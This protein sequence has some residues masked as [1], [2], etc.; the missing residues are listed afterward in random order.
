MHAGPSTGSRSRPGRVPRHGQ[1]KCGRVRAGCGNCYDVD[2]A[3][4]EPIESDRVVEPN[5]E[6][7]QLPGPSLWPVGFAIGIACLLVG[8]IVSWIVAAVGAGLALVFAF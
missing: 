6:H 3:P 5:R 1:R 2:R 4:A 8:L 7:P